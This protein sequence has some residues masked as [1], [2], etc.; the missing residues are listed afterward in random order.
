MRGAWQLGVGFLSALILLTGCASKSI[1]VAASGELKVS[2]E[3][4]PLVELPSP[5]VT[6]QDGVLSIS[7]IVK[8]KAGVDGE[9]PG[10][11]DLVFSDAKGNEINRLRMGWTP[12]ELPT[13]GA[14]QSGYSVNYAWL[15]TP[16]DSLKISYHDDWDPIPGGYGRSVGASAKVGMV[17]WNAPGGRVFNAGSLPQEPR[18]IPMTPQ[19]REGDAMPGYWNSGRHK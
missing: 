5:T 11:I 14:R 17:Q 8:R 13:T 12:R 19:L 1:D 18:S 3:S 6:K 15:P 16:G 9:I 4:A 2:T 10:H 7:G